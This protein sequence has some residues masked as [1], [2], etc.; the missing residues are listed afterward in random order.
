MTSNAEEA[1]GNPHILD[2]AS[3]TKE[4]GGLLKQSVYKTLRL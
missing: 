2:C 4:L 1:K 3:L